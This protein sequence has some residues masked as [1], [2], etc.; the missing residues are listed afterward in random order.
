MRK[1]CNKVVPIA[2]ALSVGPTSAGFGRLRCR[3]CLS[4]PLEA[5]VQAGRFV[6]ALSKHFEYVHDPP[7]KNLYVKDGYMDANMLS[8]TISTKPLLSPFNL[9][10]DT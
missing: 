10:L 1:R 9:F 3:H 8:D 6:G 4:L 5:F 7:P 2:P